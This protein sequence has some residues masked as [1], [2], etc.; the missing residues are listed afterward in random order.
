M[1]APGRVIWELPGTYSHPVGMTSVRSIEKA[2]AP[3][4]LVVVMRQVNGDPM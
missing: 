3:P 1:G 4:L 2:G